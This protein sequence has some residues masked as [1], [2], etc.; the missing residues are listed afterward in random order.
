MNIIVC[1]AQEDKYG[2]TKENIF[3]AYDD[4]HNYLG[5]SYVYPTINYHQTNETP[6]LLFIGIQVGEQ[7]E[8]S[9]ADEVKQRL[10]DAVLQRAKV[11][12][13]ERNELKCRIYAGFQYDEKKLAFYLKNGFEEDYSIFM[14]TTILEST[15]ASL[16]KDI[17]VGEYSVANKENL[18]SF[19]AQYDEI[20]VSPLDGE[21]FAAAQKDDKS[22]KN[23]YFY[24]DGQLVGECSVREENECGWIEILYVL[25][26]KRGLGISKK[27]MNYI[28]Q[29]FL[30]KGIHKVKLEVWGINKRAVSLYESFGYKEVGRGDM[31]PGITI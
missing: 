1:Q 2:N 5:N 3:I 28:H 22:F 24:L 13:E 20:F 11:L 27:M 25:Q 4:R 21:G 14:E 16:P 10:F 15:Y 8:Q 18:A 12:R 31:F 29:Y 6:Y 7:I 30:E 19:K 9:L 23:F 17:Q 26:Q